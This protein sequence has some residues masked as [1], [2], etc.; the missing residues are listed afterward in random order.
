[1]TSICTYSVYNTIPIIFCTM[2]MRSLKKRSVLRYNFSS[3]SSTS[4]ALCI[5]ITFISEFSFFHSLR[6][7]LFLPLFFTISYSML[8]TPPTY[9]LCLVCLSIFLTSLCLSLFYPYYNLTLYVCLFLITVS[10]PFTH[11]LSLFLPKGYRRH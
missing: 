8:V 10:P 1:M 4:L 2:R 7:P 9:L 3:F 6:S 5:V 11:S